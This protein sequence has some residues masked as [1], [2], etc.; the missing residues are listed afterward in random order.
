MAQLKKVLATEPD[1]LISSPKIHVVEERSSVL[2]Q[3]FPHLNAH[4]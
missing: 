1:D 3:V 4:S 2:S